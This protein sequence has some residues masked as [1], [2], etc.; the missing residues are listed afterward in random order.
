MALTR[1][2]VAGLLTLTLWCQVLPVERRMEP[3]PTRL[4]QSSQMPE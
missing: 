3:S 2:V 4:E 1:I